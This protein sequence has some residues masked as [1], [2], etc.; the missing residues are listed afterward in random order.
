MS[1]GCASSCSDEFKARVAELE[2][3]LAEARENAFCDAAMLAAAERCA[4]RLA[5]ALS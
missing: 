2:V 1:V 4:E 5:N 3:L